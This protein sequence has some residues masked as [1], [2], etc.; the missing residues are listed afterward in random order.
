M[1]KQRILITGA[2]GQL[3]QALVAAASGDVRLQN[4]FD[5]LIPKRHELDL[6]QPLQCAEFI[7]RHKP[8]WLINAAAYTAV[9][10][11]ESDQELAFKANAQ[12]PAA[13]ASA[14]QLVGGKMIQIS[15]DFVFDGQQGKPYLPQD[16]TSAMSV[17]GQSKQQGEQEVLSRLADTKS[18]HVVRTSWLYGPTGH[19]FLH[20]MLYLHRSYVIEKKAIRVVADQVGSPT[21][22]ADLADFCWQLIVASLQERSDIP[23]LLHWSDAGVAS[24]YDFAVAIGEFA[25]HYR[26]ITRQAEVVPITSKQYPTPAQRPH[27]S[28]LGQCSFPQGPQPRHWRFALDRVLSAMASRDHAP[29]AV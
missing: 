23:L 2:S 26:L 16:Q 22:S 29:Q 10:Q 13:F 18:C 15:T 12:A 6:Y 25:E 11:A 3:G 28:V 9:D 27:F 8:N 1:A 19:N 17:Y 7:H 4:S 24:W 5:L 21:N 14:L 20:T